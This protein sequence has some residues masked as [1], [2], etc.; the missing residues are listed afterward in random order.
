MYVRDCGVF[1][2]QNSFCEGLRCSVFVVVRSVCEEM[3]F[4]PESSLD[5]GAYIVCPKYLEVEKKLWTF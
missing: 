5:V 3:G 2:G 4:Q 1:G